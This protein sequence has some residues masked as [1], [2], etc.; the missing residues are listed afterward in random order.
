M[1]SK[2]IILASATIMALPAFSQKKTP[3]KAELEASRVIEFSNSV[4]KMGNSNNEIFITYQELLQAADNNAER[5]SK[6]P[7]LQPFYVN[8][9]G[10]P[11]RTEQ[12]TAYKTAVKAVQSF[13]EKADIEKYVETGNNHMNSLSKWCASISAFFTDKQYKPDNDFSKYF[14]MR[15]SLIHYLDL[16]SKNWRSASAQA[17]V[18]GNRAEMV[19]LEGSKLASFVIPMKTD[20]N[21]LDKIFGMF[22]SQE[23][24][25][26][27]IRSQLDQLTA[28]IEKNKDISTK[29]LSKLQDIY[30]KEVYETFYRKCGETAKALQGLTDRI[31]E[32]SDSDMLNRWFGTANSNYSTA[33]EKYNLFISQ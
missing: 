21:S 15:D 26:Q 23:I 24:D 2:F 11:T 10:I 17:S 19:L 1:K 12:V 33:V 9:K 4:I 6:N 25:I 5:L 22:N 20:L 3:T 7:N 14:I 13:P 18:A 27:A 32:S 16:S 8:C 31:E 30:Y 28:S 29:D